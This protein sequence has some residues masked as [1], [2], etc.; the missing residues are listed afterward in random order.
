M[1][2]DLWEATYEISLDCGDHF[3]RVGNSREALEVLM[4]CWPR[5]AGKNF[6]V[7]KKACLGAL[8]GN[9]SSVVAAQAFLNAAKEAG[10]LR[11]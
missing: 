5:P 8:R 4:T 10:L 7:A 9:V 1:Q 3:K 2:N 11:P 6:K